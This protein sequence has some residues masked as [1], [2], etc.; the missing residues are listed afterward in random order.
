MVT[1]RCGKAEMTSTCTLCS[2]ASVAWERIRVR[3]PAAGCTPGFQSEPPW[4]LSGAWLPGSPSRRSRPNSP[5]GRRTA[6]FQKCK[7]W[8]H[9]GSFRAGTRSS[10]SHLTRSGTASGYCSALRL[11]SRLKCPDRKE[12]RQPCIPDSPPHRGLLDS[13]SSHH[14]VGA[15]RSTPGHL[16]KGA[17]QE[18]SNLW[19]AKTQYQ[20]KTRQ[21][22]SKW[23]KWTVVLTDRNKK[24]SRE[25]WRFFKNPKQKQYLLIALPD[26]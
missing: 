11:G 8:F 25:E 16:H 12:T 24:A 6:T 19:P 15:Q 9:S 26:R 2:W 21:I 23:R 10:S 4:S 17:R 13:A 14:S 7:G 18:N 5:L 22:W 3:W 1:S 20:H